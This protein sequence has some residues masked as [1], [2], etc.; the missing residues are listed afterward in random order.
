MS[1][2]ISRPQ[3]NNNTNPSST[4]RNTNTMS[5]MQRWGNETAH[6]R[7]WDSVDSIYVTDA[8]VGMEQDRGALNDIDGQNEDSNVD[9][10]TCEG[11]FE[12]WWS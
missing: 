6:E 2:P 1:H 3:L 8:D 9:S 10:M 12:G 5:V 7:P 11:S 4:T